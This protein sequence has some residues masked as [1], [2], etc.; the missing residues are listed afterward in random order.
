M[1]ENVVDLVDGVSRIYE[2]SNGK[3]EVSKICEG[4]LAR[5]LELVRGLEGGDCDD[6]DEEEREG[7]LQID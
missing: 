7:I 1:S 4:S 3:V 6:N 2:I 5:T